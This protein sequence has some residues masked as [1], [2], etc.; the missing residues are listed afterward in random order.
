MKDI[1]DVTTRIPACSTTL[2]TRMSR[3][4]FITV[5]SAAKSKNEAFD[6][7]I[8][9]LILYVWILKHYEPLVH[10]H[11]ILDLLQPPKDSL[12]HESTKSICLSLG[13]ADLRDVR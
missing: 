4:R 12:I 8:V 7:L 11:P 6:L 3:Q 1:D 2:R 9:A 10:G 5:A 13:Q